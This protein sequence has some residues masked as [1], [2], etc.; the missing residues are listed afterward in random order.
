MNATQRRPR[1]TRLPRKVVPPVAGT[2]ES[3]FEV[4]AAYRGSPSGGFYG[5]LA[6]VRTTDGR[7][8]YPFEGAAEIG[9]FGSKLEA[10]DA[11]KRQGLAIIDGDLLRPEL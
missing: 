6:V 8:L 5:T 1:T 9:P 3:D 11:A 10:V 7:L 4:Y 2:S